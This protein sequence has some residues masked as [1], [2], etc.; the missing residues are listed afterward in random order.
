[1]NTIEEKKNRLNYELRALLS[2]IDI[3]DGLKGEY[4][5]YE[6]NTIS[7]EEY[8]DEQIKLVVDAKTRLKSL[9]EK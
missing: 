5:N 2:I 8:L 9:F 3:I 1:M 6:P 4:K 7:D